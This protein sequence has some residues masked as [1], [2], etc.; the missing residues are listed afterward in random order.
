MACEISYEHLRNRLKNSKGFNLLPID[1][2]A[3]Q[4][5]EYIRQIS[6][7]FRLAEVNVDPTNLG[8]DLRRYTLFTDDNVADT[9]AFINQRV[10]DGSARKFRRRMLTS[11]TEEELLAWQNEPDKVIKREYGTAVHNVLDALGKYYYEVAT[12]GS[13]TIDLQQVRHDAANNEYPIEGQHFTALENNAKK[14]IT[15]IINT[16][17]RIDPNGKVEIHFERVVVD[18]TQDIAGTIDV[19]AVFSDKSAMIYDYKTF[20]SKVDYVEGSGRNKRIISRNFAIQ[21]KREAWKEQMSGYRRIL[22]DNYGITTIRATRVVPIWLDYNRTP[23]GNKYVINKSLN[24]LQMGEDMNEYLRNISIGFEKTS[25]TV[26][27]NFLESYYKRLQTLKEL[28]NKADASERE[29]ILNQIEATEQGIYEF[30]EKDKL[31]RLIGD[32]LNLAT[33]INNDLDNEQK[34][35]YEQLN[36]GITFVSSVVD[37]LRAIEDNSA[38]ME[39][40][41]PHLIEAIKDTIKA[42][43]EPVTALAKVAGRLVNERLDTVLATVPDQFGTV[44]REGQTITM[45]DDS[46]LSQVFLPSSEQENPIVRLGVDRMQRSLSDT[47]EEL[48]DFVEEFATL[49]TNVEQWLNSQGQNLYDLH[50]YLLD[51]DHNLVNRLSLDF[52]AEKKEALRNGDVAFFTRFYKVREENYRGETYEQSFER[53][54]QESEDHYRYYYRELE[55][56]NPDK[57]KRLIF[58]KME[59]WT[60][61]NDLTL[62]EDGTPKYNEAW[63]SDRFLEPNEQAY[64]RYENSAYTIIRTTPELQAYYTFVNEFIKTYRPIVGYDVIRRAN[65]F[66]KVR[67]EMVEKLSNLD[68]KGIGQDIRKILSIREDETS[69]GMYNATTGRIDKSVPVFFTNPLN[70]E[71]Q[72]SNDIGNSMRLFAKVLINYKHMTKVEVEVLA[73]KEI[74]ANNVQY[75]KTDSIGRKVLDKF[76]QLA[77]KNESEGSSLTEQVFSTYVDYYLYGVN[78]QVFNNNPKLT[79]GLMKAKNYFSL[80]TL[81]LGIIPGTASFVAAGASAWVEGQKGIYYDKEQWSKGMTEMVSNGKKYHGIAYFFGVHNNDMLEDITNSV[82]NTV[83]TFKDARYTRKLQQYF[84]Q[85]MLMR[86]FSLGDEWLDNHIAVSMAMNYGIDSSGRLRRMENLDEGSKSIY[87]MFSVDNEGVVDFD[88]ENVREAVYQFRNAVRK[89]QRK[90][91]GTISDEDTNYAQRHLILNLIMQFKTWMPG[92]LAERFGKIRYDD[93]LDAMEGGRYKVLWNELTYAEKDEAAKTSLYFI[94]AT[95]TALL[96]FSKLILTNNKLARLTGFEY[97]LDDDQLR[98]EFEMLKLLNNDPNMTVADFTRLKQGQLRAV[99][100]ELEVLLMFTSMLFALGMDWDEDGDP[101]YKEYYGLHSIYKILNRVKTEIS[102]AYNPSEYSKLVT[103]PIPLSSLAVNAF[104]LLGNTG[105][106]IGDVLFGEETKRFP[107]PFGANKDGK[108]DATDKFHYVISFVP[109]A[110]QLR[111]MFDDDYGPKDR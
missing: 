26:V 63:L 25:N 35:S 39:H 47:R 13:S 29:G 109:G 44:Q 1:P 82:N 83:N 87:E 97:K 78:T 46:M 102:F 69:F 103:S 6:D 91:K 28:Y 65:F 32:T 12:N 5:N 3:A 105:D 110:Y 41:Q 66:P 111:R 73:I 90:I 14:L 16:Q 68:F 76:H 84:N 7:R 22:M 64:E 92:V 54:K 27:D 50:N 79:Y 81:G 99:V 10:T 4:I 45:K 80:K 2:T 30:V 55:K 33:E 38:E 61:R 31:T 18:P 95:G 24:I 23:E 107:I 52:Y 34:L 67:S 53:R 72:L 94:Q 8:D 89:A 21:S 100:A 42:L 106:E 77:I 70:D 57:F 37:F 85:R 93:T 71:G 96:R 20:S 17:K 48:R 43:N 58:S 9:D 74:L 60:K 101:L 49:E 98:S 40:E 36:D 62:K 51:N 104:N 11:M 86:S 59:E 15:T 75:Y 56:T 19:L 108:S 88:T